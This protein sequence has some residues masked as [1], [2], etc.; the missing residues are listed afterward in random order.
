[1][2][3]EQALKE[4]TETMKQLIAVM[5]AARSTGCQ[6]SEKVA[7][8]EKPASTPPAKAEVKSAAKPEAAA[9]SPSEATLTYK[10][11]QKAFLAL[12]NK[13][14]DTAVALVAE[15]GVPTLKAFEKAD[16]AKLAEL[17]ALIEEKSNAI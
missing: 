9:A 8:V 1:M 10:D 12:V 11:V 17:L 13:D 6:G 3:L 7:L 4:N 5:E 15:L 16:Q 2:S 14:H